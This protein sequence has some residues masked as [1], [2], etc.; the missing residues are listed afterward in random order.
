MA[1]TA[2]TS[3]KKD[4]FILR[5]LISKDFKLKYR[6]SV[7]GIIWSVLN[8]LLM[9]LVINAVFSFIFRFDIVNFP[10]YLIL[11]LTLFNLMA[12]STSAAVTSIIGAASL[13]KKIRVN[14]LLF[15]I[16]TVL[17]ELVNYGLSL[18]AVAAVMIFWANPTIVPTLNLLFLPLLLVYMVIFCTGLSLLLSSLAVFFRDVIHLWNVVI[19]AWTYVTPLFYP[20]D[21]LAPWMKAIMQFNPMYHFVTYLREIALWGN[22]PGLMENLICLGMALLTFAVGLLVFKRTERKFILYV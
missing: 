9:M 3:L 1:L 14:K 8:P 19:I 22:N 7:L 6:R 20:I 12:N 13:I 11:G 15:P 4:L 21:L 18:I 16:E 17:F 5:Q 2:N 10:V